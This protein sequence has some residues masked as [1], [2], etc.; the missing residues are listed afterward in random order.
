MKIYTYFSSLKSFALKRVFFQ[1]SEKSWIYGQKSQLYNVEL[2]NVDFSSSFL[3][4]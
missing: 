1:F 2:A 3:N 4:F